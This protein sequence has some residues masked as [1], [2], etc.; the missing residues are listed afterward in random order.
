MQISE[1]SVFATIVIL[2]FIWRFA[3]THQLYRYSLKVLRGHMEPTQFKPSFSTD[4]LNKV[5]LGNRSVEP[6]SFFLR[7]LVFVSVA[8]VLLPFRDYAPELYWIVTF[9]IVLYV[10]W[11]VGHGTG[12]IRSR[13]ICIIAVSFLVTIV[14]IIAGLTYRQQREKRVSLKHDRLW[15]IPGRILTQVSIQLTLESSTRVLKSF[16]PYRRFLI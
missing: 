11:C 13:I 3:R 15:V 16:A 10:P 6:N 14:V 4:F 9:L 12:D 1:E 7:A 5:L 8:L 2:F